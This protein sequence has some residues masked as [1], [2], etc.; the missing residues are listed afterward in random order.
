MS[1]NTDQPILILGTRTFAE[2]VADLIDETPG[3]RVAGFVENMDRD[4]CAK[5]L[6]DLPVYWIDDIAPLARTHAAVCALSTTL[7]SRFTDQAAALG[8]PFATVI[9]PSAHVSGKSTVGEGSI[10]SVGVIIAAYT[11]LGRHVIVSRGAGIGHHT[12]IGDYVTI[13]PGVNVAGS[14]QIGQAAYIGIGATIID[15]LT[16]GEHSFVGAGAVVVR[17]VP[18]HMKVVGVPARIIEKNIP[19][20]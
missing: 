17:D 10:I 14:C 18:P 11:H 9:H 16:V 7:R 3:Y 20:S 15:K 8:M 4:R 5:T 2:H 19:G 12:L 13:Q 6:L 1:A